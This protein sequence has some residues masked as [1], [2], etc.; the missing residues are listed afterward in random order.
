MGGGDAEVD[1]ALEGLGWP[2][3]RSSGCPHPGTVPSAH[4]GWAWLGFRVPSSPSSTAP[5]PW[6]RSGQLTH[7]QHTNCDFIW[8]AKPQEKAQVPPSAPWAR[9]GAGNKPGMF[10]GNVPQECSSSIWDRNPESEPF[11]GEGR[12]E[13]FKSGISRV[14]DG[15]SL[16]HQGCREH[17]PH[18]PQPSQELP[19]DPSD[20]TN[21]PGLSPIRALFN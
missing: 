2:S 12:S 5:S 7:G 8:F 3:Q 16:R 18:T 15:P 4:A 17:Q 13:E 10:L 6:A 14:Q 9:G 19:L 21:T 1:P 20:L 11:H